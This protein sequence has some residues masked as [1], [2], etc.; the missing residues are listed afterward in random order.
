MQE[1]PA[2][3]WVGEIP[4]RRGRLLTPAFLGFSCGSDGKEPACDAGELG[5]IRG[6]GRSPGGGHG[7]SLQYSYLENARGQRNL[8]GYSQS[9][10]SQR[11]GHDSNW[12]PWTW[13]L[14]LTIHPIRCASGLS[15]NNIY[16]APTMWT[17]TILSTG[18]SSGEQ[19]RSRL[20]SYGHYNLH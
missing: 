17:G 5:L 1:T 16:W 15:L 4:W 14:T 6:L 12:A 8:A 18:V 11:V 2:Q 10:G 9:M 19:D 7:N 13:A 20:C 3:P